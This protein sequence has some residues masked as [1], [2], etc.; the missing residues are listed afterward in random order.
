MQLVVFGATGGIGGHVV[1]QALDRGDHVT[2]V[3]R[4]MSR[5]AVRH[6][7]LD[8]AVADLT[9]P[10]ALAL[11]EALSGVEAAVSAVGPRRRGDAG[12]ATAATRTILAALAA[13]GVRHLVA[14]SAAPVG[15]Q[16][17]G[18]DLLTRRVVLPA[19]RRVLRDVYADLAAMEDAIRR[20]GLEWTIVRPPKLTNGPRTGRYRTAPENVRH[21]RTISRADVADAML[22]AIDDTAR[23]NRAVG[24]AN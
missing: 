12:V 20:S 10:R 7:R 13:G 11:A 8:V 6:E 19:L 15:P 18:E 9:D 16:P 14:V 4:D 2:A 22:A 23:A 1:R 21:G 3:V 5:L 17:A 24:V